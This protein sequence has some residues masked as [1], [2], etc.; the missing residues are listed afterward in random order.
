MSDDLLSNALGGLSPSSNNRFSRPIETGS[1]GKV[2]YKFGLVKKLTVSSQEMGTSTGK[3]YFVSKKVFKSISKEVFPNEKTGSQITVN[4]YAERTQFGSQTPTGNALQ[5]DRPS[6]TKQASPGEETSSTEQA[7]ETQTSKTSSAAREPA[8]DLRGKTPEVIFQQVRLAAGLRKEG[9]SGEAEQIERRLGMSASSVEKLS[10]MKEK[11]FLHVFSAAHKLGYA[12][13]NGTTVDYQAGTK[14]NTLPITMDKTYQTGKILVHLP[15]DDNGRKPTL[16]FDYSGNFEGTYEKGRSSEIQSNFA[17]FLIIEKH[18]PSAE[19]LPGLPI[20]GGDDV[21]DYVPTYS[22]IAGNLPMDQKLNAARGAAEGLATLHQEGLSHNQ[23]TPENVC[24][25][26]SG[27][28]VL[29]D[30]SRAGQAHDN[31][32][33]IWDFGNSLSQVLYGEGAKEPLREPESE[34]EAHAQLAIRACMN[35]I[36]QERPSASEVLDILDGKGVAI[37]P[38][39]TPALASYL[40][41]LPQHLRDK[42]PS[43]D[44]HAAQEIFPIMFN[45]LAVE[46]QE[47]DLNAHIG[48]MVGLSA[49]A[50]AKKPSM[51]SLKD[52]L[53]VIS[54]MINFEPEELADFMPANVQSLEDAK[55]EGNEYAKAV[56]TEVADAMGIK[57][58]D[59]LQEAFGVIKDSIQQNSKFAYLKP[60]FTEF[61]RLI[62]PDQEIPTVL[63]EQMQY[64]LKDLQAIY[65]EAMKK[66]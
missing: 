48:L 15:K 12:Q 53:A 41:S 23:V 55:Q 33:D 32:A 54:E 38:K 21:T 6:Q 40:D 43:L 29:N 36:P 25:D 10:Q 17:E 35:P 62:A 47:F 66:R 31:S 22:S 50:P 11:D 5:S 58:P 13:K 9:K 16:C 37:E 14:G 28:G 27:K 24:I 42:G 2:A 7:R 30:L 1:L 64:H 3:T 34:Q 26:P 59:D 65:S 18:H 52:N 63:C 4:K 61:E 45:D 56:L 20:R 39:P 44:Q 46:G 51:E 60:A 19:H 8:K 57:L 49:G